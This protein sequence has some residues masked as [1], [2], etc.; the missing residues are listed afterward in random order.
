MN[1]TFDTFLPL[2]S[3][4]VISITTVVVMLAIAFFRNHW[5][6]ATLTVVGL[7]IALITTIYLAIEQKTGT[8]NNSK[9][10]K[11]EAM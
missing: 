7:N 11:N 3:L 6:N 2:L 1:L 8:D 4:G 5:W 10:I 9:P